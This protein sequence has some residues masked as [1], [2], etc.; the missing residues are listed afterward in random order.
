MAFNH[1]S[2]FHFKDFMNLYRKRTAKPYYFLAIYTTLASDNLLHF[3]E[4]TLERIQK[5]I[6]TI[7]ES[8]RHY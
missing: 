8:K 4:D 2:D 5:L 3:R 6:I 7:D 1:S